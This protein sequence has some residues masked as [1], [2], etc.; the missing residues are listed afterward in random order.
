MGEINVSRLTTQQDRFH[1]MNHLL[2]DLKALEQMLDHSIIENDVKRVG[3]EQ[4]FCI[5]D[6]RFMPLGI[7]LKLLDNLSDSNFTTEI[8]NYNLEVNL[9]P[10]ILGGRCFSTLHLNLREKLQKAQEEAQKFKANIVLTGILPTISAK[11]ISLENMT[12]VSRYAILNEAIKE[13]RKQDF[14][15]HIRGADEFNLLHDS[16]MLEGCNTSFQMHLQISPDEFV[17]SYNWAQAISGPV[18]ASATNSPLLFGKELWAET[19][20]AL[21]TQSV[22]TR[23]RS[24]LL[25][26]KHS[27]VSFGSD[28]HKGSVVDIF[29]ENVFGY[30]SLL[31]SEYI[32]DSVEML[33]KN[34]IPQLKALSL[35]NGTVYRWNRPCYGVYNNKPHL[36][37]ENRYIPAGPTM[38]DEIANMVFWVGLMLAKPDNMDEITSQW[39]YKDV[40][41]N[42]YAAARYGLSSQ[43]FWNNKFVAVDDL[44][45][46]ELIPLA[47]KGLIKNHVDI[48]EA[49]FYLG[50]IEKRIRYNTGS[51]WTVKSFRNLLKRHKA[52]KASQ[53]L[54][55]FMFEKQRKDYPVGRWTILDINQSKD[56]EIPDEIKNHMSFSVFTADLTDSLQFAHEIMLW[57]NI[58]HLPIIDSEQHLIG[59][60]SWSDIEQLDKGEL[61]KS[62]IEDFMVRNPITICEYDSLEKAR[63][64][65]QENNFHSL[66]VMRANKLVGI[67]TSKDFP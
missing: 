57:K 19:R 46:N 3:A 38:I 63:T 49:D 67:I 48:D 61:C 20:I 35:H 1:Y 65:M 18:L 52:Y 45:L 31:T 55:A 43:M 12:P 41:N 58:H 25:N 24:N 33:E 50:I 27:R 21:F 34:E 11:D 17:D 2:K 32:L 7:G 53:L 59:L 66:P 22:D 5:T 30:R 23:A 10:L 51:S 6:E 13:S 47:Y 37:I 39:H 26:H 64:L 4:E 8:G 60:L 44:I 15:I 54:T 40:K 56:F 9:D 42:F 29:K 28:W 16:V 36:R 62:S 14:S